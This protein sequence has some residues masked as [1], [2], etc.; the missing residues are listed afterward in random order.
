MGRITAQFTFASASLVVLALTLQVVGLNASFRLL[1]V[2]L[3]V[4]VLVTGS[5]TAL[6]VRNASQQDLM[7]VVGM[8]RLRAAYIELDPWIRDHLV[9]G[10]TDDPAGIGRTYDMGIKRTGLSHFFASAFVFAGAVN[11]IVAAGLGAVLADTAGTGG[12]ATTL[13]G[14]ASAL[15]YAAVVF[16]PAHRGYRRVLAQLPPAATVEEIT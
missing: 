14:A 16:V 5:L 10:W 1:A 6:R 11:I 15:L 12:V 13:I 9:T 8:N 7:L 4:S 2:W 3:G